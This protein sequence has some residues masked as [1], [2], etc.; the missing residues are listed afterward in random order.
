MIAVIQQAVAGTDPQAA[1]LLVHRQI[2]NGIV[3][4]LGCV[5]VIKHLEPHPIEPH[6]PLERAD[7]EIPIARL[8]QRLDAVL[9]QPV[10]RRPVCNAILRPRG[11]SPL[12]HRMEECRGEGSVSGCRCTS[13]NNQPG[14]GQPRQDRL[15]DES[16]EH[17]ALLLP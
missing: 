8:R 11:Q 4:H 14:K 6:Q 12:A 15:L 13:W 7:P 10:L 9:R 1:I 5:A 16:A 3:R 2:V 17:L